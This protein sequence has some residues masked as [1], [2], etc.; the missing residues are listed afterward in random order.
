MK[1][2][3][4]LCLICVEIHHI[5]ITGYEKK[6]GFKNEICQIFYEFEGESESKRFNYAYTILPRVEGR[7]NVN[8]SGPLVF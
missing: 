1:K 4:R 6:S 2:L 7:N 8:K 5:V 3:R